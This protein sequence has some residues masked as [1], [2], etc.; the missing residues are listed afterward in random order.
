MLSES[1]IDLG[2]GVFKPYLDQFVV[3]FIDDILVYSK[4]REE[5]EHHLSIVLQ[6]LKDKQLY[7]KLKKCGFWLD[8][9]SFLGH[10]VTKN[11][12][13]IDPGKVDAVSNWMRPNTVIEIQSFLGLAS[14]YKRFIDGFFKIALPMTKLTQKMVKFEWS[15][16]CECSFQELKNILVTTSILTISSSLGGFVMYSDASRQGLGCVLMQPGK[17]VAYAPR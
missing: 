17:V 6:T 5:H 9:V 16:D 14:Y 7:A 13:S 3:V 12:I 15:N 11:G 1:I 4:S 8:K 10:V 2:V